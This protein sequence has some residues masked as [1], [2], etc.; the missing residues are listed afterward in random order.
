MCGCNAEIEDTEHIL[1]RCHFHSI[2]RFEPFNNI[3]KVVPSFTLLDTK[4]QIC[5]FCCM[6]IH[7]TNLTTLIKILSN[8]QLVFFKNLVVLINH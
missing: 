1:L 2:Q 3:K 5:V 4:E 7:P 6:V 8:L